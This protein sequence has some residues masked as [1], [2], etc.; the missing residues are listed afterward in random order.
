MCNDPERMP[1]TFF[2]SFD[3][4]KICFSST[5]ISTFACDTSY[6]T[7]EIL[8]FSLSSGYTQTMCI[9]MIKNVRHCSLQQVFALTVCS[10]QRAEKMCS[11]DFSSLFN[12]MIIFL[13]YILFLNMRN[14]HRV[15][16][17]IIFYISLIVQ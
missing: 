7:V 12:H 6:T 4:S 13:I 10:S 11:Q 9:F 5:G 14:V 3:I 15:H 16:D 1:N 8:V 2:L 17:K